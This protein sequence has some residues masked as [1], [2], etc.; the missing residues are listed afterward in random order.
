M[1]SVTVKGGPGASAAIVPNEKLRLAKKN[2][3]VA[4]TARP[5]TQQV[6]SPSSGGQF[7]IKNGDRRR[8]ENDDFRG[9]QLR[10]SVVLV[11]E[12]Q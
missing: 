8:P 1:A 11:F 9:G 12:I 4:R 3:L 6:D 10:K 7:R 2:V 5:G